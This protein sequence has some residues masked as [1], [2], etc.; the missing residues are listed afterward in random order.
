MLEEIF[1]DIFVVII[2]LTLVIFMIKGIIH[3]IELK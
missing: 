1:Q 3:L 2:C